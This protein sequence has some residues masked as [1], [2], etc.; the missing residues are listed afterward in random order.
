VLLNE[1][2]ADKIYEMVITHF[3]GGSLVRYR[4]GDMIRITSLRNEKLGIDIPQ[5][6]FERRADDLIDLGLIRLTEKVIWQ[7]IEN[8]NIPNAGWT[9]RKE[10]AGSSPAL[11]LYLELKD[12]YIAS[13]KGIATAIYDQLK[14]LD[15]GFIHSDVK[16]IETLID[17]KPVQ[18]T[19]LPEGAFTNYVAHRQSE[20]A[21]LAHLK[22]PHMN[23]SDE[24]LTLLMMKR[25]TPLEEE[26]IS[27]AQETTIGG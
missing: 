10:I 9:A 11:H 8:S 17:F 6:I 12:N 15:D 14:K 1:V 25:K 27:E 2:K 26:K 3:H 18:V 19:I 22:P 5:M 4:P 16:S 7:A 20:G 23:P 21:D 24:I 13:E